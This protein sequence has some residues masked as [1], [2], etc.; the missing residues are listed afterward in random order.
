MLEA[1]F[2]D[3]GQLFFGRRRPIHFDAENLS[4]LHGGGAYASGDSVDQHAGGLALLLIEIDEPSLPVREIRR[5]EI[6]REGGALLRRPAFWDGPEQS[7]LDGSLFGES[8]P[9]R[10]AHDAAACGIKPSEFA[11]R[12]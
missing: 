4:D 8:G 11:S 6:H 10:V 9:L 1:E 2:A 3:A 7:A 5:E 12:D